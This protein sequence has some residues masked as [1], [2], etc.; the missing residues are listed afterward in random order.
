[1]RCFSCWPITFLKCTH[2]HRNED[3]DSISMLCFYNNATEN[4]KEQYRVYMLHKYVYFF[5][6]MNVTEPVAEIVVVQRRMKNAKG[7]Y[8]I[9]IIVL[10]G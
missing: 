8:A 9:M 5:Q 7:K 3:D 10:G 4:A 6:E 2:T 1:M